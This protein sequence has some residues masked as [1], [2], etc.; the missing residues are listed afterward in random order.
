MAKETKATTPKREL[1]QR[2]YVDNH[3]TQEEVA[4]IIGVTRQ[5]IIRWSKTYH[6]QELRAA[7][8]ITPAEQIRQLRGQIAQINEA[9]NARPQG[10]RWAPPAEADSLNQLASAIQKLEKDVGIE[11]LIAVAMRM[12]AWVRTSN[13]EEAKNLSALFNAYIQEVSGGAARR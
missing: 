8:S 7:T 3:Y 9:I 2:L 5:T 12:T 10:E 11:D 6:W 13:A 4:S 1:A